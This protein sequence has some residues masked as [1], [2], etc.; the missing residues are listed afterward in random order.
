MVKVKSMHMPEVVDK[1][2]VKPLSGLSIFGFLVDENEI[3]IDNSTNWLYM[4]TLL[5][6]R[7][8]EHSI[9]KFLYKIDFPY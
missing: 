9:V 3:G 8:A 7:L 1:C 5:Q 4:T 6:D 2:K